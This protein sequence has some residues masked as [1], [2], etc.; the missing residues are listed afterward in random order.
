VTRFLL[1]VWLLAISGAR[2]RAQD[3]YQIYAVRFATVPSFPVSAL[4]ADADTARRADLAM[5]VWLVKG[6]DGRNILVDAG[7]Y[8]AKFLERWKPAD[9]VRPSEALRP[10]G[11]K[12]DE[13]T[14]IIISHIHWDH[15][16]GLDLFPKARVWIQREEYEYYVGADGTP[17]NRGIDP[18]DAPVLATLRVTGRVKLVPGDA[19]EIIP[20]ITCYTGGRHTYASQ[21]VGVR[22]GGQTVLL[23]SDNLYLYENLERRVPIAQT[24]DSAAN[25]AA[26][27]RM[28][29]IA[30]EPRLIVPGHDALVFQRFPAVAPGIVRIR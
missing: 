23:A 15:L 18:D 25:R 11:V 29:T 2:A 10:L 9:F 14:D 22:T 8:R 17:R 27:E 30:T 21:Y 4:M 16:D 7:F 3:A 12:P 6:A 26:Q 13:V 1:A 28:L 24:L 5:M 20:G 19:Q